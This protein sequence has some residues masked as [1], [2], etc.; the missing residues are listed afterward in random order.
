MS[1]FT[2]GIRT[3]VF[4]YS[5]NTHVLS[6]YQVPRVQVPGNTDECNRPSPHGACILVGERNN[7]KANKY[8]I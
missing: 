3:H 1:D 2:S 5:F 8:I 4:I 7:Q 6:A